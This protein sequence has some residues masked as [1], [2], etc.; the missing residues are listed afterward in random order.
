M[1][2][3]DLARL[4]FASTPTY[5]FLLVSLTICSSAC[6]MTDAPRPRD[7]RGCARREYWR[8]WTTTVRSPPRVPGA[9]PGREALASR[10]H[11][12]LD[13]RLR[14][15]LSH[16]R[17][18]QDRRRVLPLP[19]RHPDRAPPLDQPSSHPLPLTNPTHRPTA[20]L[21]IKL[22]VAPC[23]PTELV[24]L[25]EDHFQCS[26]VPGD[27]EGAQRRHS[28]TGRA[29]RP[30]G[31]TTPASSDAPEVRGGGCHCPAVPERAAPPATRGPPSYGASPAEA[32]AATFKNGHGHHPL[33]A[34][35][36]IAPPVSGSRCRSCC[37]PGN[38][39]SSPASAGRQILAALGEG[40][41]HANCR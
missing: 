2:T 36:S 24:A 39:G 34:S 17:Q 21:T 4:Q 23:S 28:P 37:A 31:R 22:P 35:S 15:A 13:E 41:T 32:A 9:D 29:T 27:D 12:L 19:G 18:T 7:G 5:N 30:T 1:S 8:S 38:V 14:Q 11:P 33:W 3:V 26:P 6:C 20:A 40:N 25:D 16:H 10:A